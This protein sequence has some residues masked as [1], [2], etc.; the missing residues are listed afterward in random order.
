MIRF[1]TAI[2]IALCIPFYAFAR[3][4]D[5]ELAE[6][7]KHIDW[8]AEVYHLP[9]NGQALPL[10][11]YLSQE[12]MNIFFYGEEK[13]IEDKKKD[14]VTPVEAV[15]QPTVGSGVIYL[16]NDFHWNNIEDADTVVHELVHYLQHINKTKYSC[17]LLK[18]L[19]AYKYQSLWMLEN[20]SARQA[21][22]FLTAIAILETCAQSWEPPTED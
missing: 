20:P 12:Q 5:V 8:L 7:Q 11:V 21:P 6:M 2:L 9:H 19:D 22:T 3:D 17:N 15:F 14:N 10:V 1:I 13:Y 4:R 18:E 16:Q